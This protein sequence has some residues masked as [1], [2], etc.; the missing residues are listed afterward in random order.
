MT[1]SDATDLG[2]AIRRICQAWCAEQGYT[3]PFCRNGEWWAYPPNGVMPVPIKTVM[4][5]HCQRPV[6]LGRV[7]LF[8]YPDGSFAPEPERAALDI[9]PS[10]E[11]SVN[12]KL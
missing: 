6:R 7:T 11:C 4:D 9:I 12:S 1:L 3:D 10:N 2:D 5:T 8:L